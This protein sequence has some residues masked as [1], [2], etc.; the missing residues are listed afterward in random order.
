MQL[1]GLEPVLLEDQPSVAAR[2]T[3]RLPMATPMI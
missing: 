3:H 2:S 1:D